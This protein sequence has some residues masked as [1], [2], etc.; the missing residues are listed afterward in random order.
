M[1]SVRL[2]WDSS[3]TSSRKG[4]AR[5]Q[6]EFW[7]SSESSSAASRLRLSL[8]YKRSWRLVGSLLSSSESWA[9]T[10]TSSSTNITREK[11]LSFPFAC[12]ALTCAKPTSGCAVAQLGL[13]SVVKATLDG[14]CFLLDNGE[15]ACTTST[16]SFIIGAGVAALVIH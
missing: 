11:T 7:E 5:D 15:M 13:T 14:A 3:S 12:G 4:F 9:S 8:P 2:C 6:R 1:D 10:L 16:H